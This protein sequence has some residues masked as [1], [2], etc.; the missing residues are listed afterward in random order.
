M[1]IREVAALA[2]V[3]VRTL[4]HY[5]SKKLLCPARNPQNGYRDYTG[6]E[7]D[8]LQQILFFKSCGFTLG[9]IKSM[10]DSPQFDR[11]EALLWQKRYLLHEKARIDAML[12]A[13][14]KTLNTS[15]RIG[16]ETT[17]AAEEKR[18]GFDFSRNPYEEEA[19]RRWGDRIVDESNARLA[20]KSPAEQA[21]MGEEMSALFTRLAD[22]RTQNPASAAVQAEMEA[23]YRFFNDNFAHYTP[24]AFAGLGQMYVCDER[25]TQNID[26]FGQGLSAFLEKAMGIYAEQQENTG[27]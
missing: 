8:K 27:R 7:V 6:A 5:D 17:M 10:M 11:R 22:L 24:Q 16:E 26:Q 13:L 2:G 23:M 14:D 25:F 12:Q 3:S 9:Q 15:E 21:A 20:G 18:A 4:Q 19:R 1:T